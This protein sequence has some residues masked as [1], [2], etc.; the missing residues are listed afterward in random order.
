MIVWCTTCLFGV[1]FTFCH[2]RTRINGSSSC[3]YGVRTH[4]T[5]IAGLYRD[6]GVYRMS[7]WC[8]V[9][10]LSCSHFD[11]SYHVCKVYRWCTH[12]VVLALMGFS[13]VCMV[14]R[15]CF[16]SLSCLYGVLLMFCLFVLPLLGFCHLCVAYSVHV[17]TV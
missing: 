2:G 15:V 10:V 1:P 14:Y 3:L 5:Y 9:Y 16:G 13:R 8:T 6:C 11:R 4:R 7:G 17:V 12:A